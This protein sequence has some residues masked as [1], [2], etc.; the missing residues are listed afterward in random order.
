MCAICLLISK[1][2][3]LARVNEESHSFTIY[4]PPTPFIHIWNEAFCLHLP[5]AEHHHTLAGTHFPFR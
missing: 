5:A 3:S 1:A 2:L 4:L